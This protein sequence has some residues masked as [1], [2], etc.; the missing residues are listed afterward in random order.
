M[1]RGRKRS[2][3]GGDPAAMHARLLAQQRDEDLE[4]R[5]VR[6]TLRSV[7]Q[8]ELVLEWAHALVEGHDDT[9][10]HRVLTEK[11]HA[12][13]EQVKPGNLELAGGRSGDLLG[14]LRQCAFLTSGVSDR[15]DAT[16]V[17]CSHPA[18]VWISLVSAPDGVALEEAKQSDRFALSWGCAQRTLLYHQLYHL[19]DTLS[20]AVRAYVDSQDMSREDILSRLPTSRWYRDV[21]RLYVDPR[22]ITFLDSRQGWASTYDLVGRLYQDVV[23]CQ[24]SLLPTPEAQQ[25]VRAARE[26]DEDVIHAPRR[27]VRVVLDDD[28][29]D[30]PQ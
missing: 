7:S 26:D 8:E 19:G 23:M 27:R 2:H 21:C 25:A 29:G 10:P 12:L 11:L 17:A 20:Q 3:S 14:C 5:A 1:P 4:A 13:A 22:T 9:Q 28:D 24:E 15:M 30:S 16:C 18:Y 6:N